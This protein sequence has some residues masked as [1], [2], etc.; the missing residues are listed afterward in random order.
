M[1][2]GALGLAALVAMV[3]L[4]D[5]IL[6]FLP[7]VAGSPLSLSRPFGFAF[8][9][10][11]WLIGVPWAESETAGM[12]MGTKT[13]LN[14]LLAY[15]EVSKLPPGALCERSR[16]ILTYAMCGFANFGSLG[17]LVGGIRT[18][19]PERRNEIVALGMRSV[20]SGMPA[21]LMTGAVAGIFL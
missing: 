12:L 19:A 18:M 5:Q 9:P 4:A 10:L 17:I 7:T 20:V 11:V 16:L 3:S 21:T 8:R 2:Q 15:P 1:A 6:A 14:E 13:A